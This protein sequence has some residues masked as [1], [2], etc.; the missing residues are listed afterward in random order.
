[1][2]FELLVQV[3]H[4]RRNISALVDLAARLVGVEIT[5]RTLALAPRDVDVQAQGRRLQQS[6]C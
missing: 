5:I 1:M 6:H 4:Q 3:G 2:Q